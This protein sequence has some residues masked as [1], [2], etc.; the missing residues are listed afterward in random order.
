MEDL[1]A[2]ASS[3]PQLSDPA[4]IRVPGLGSLP[5]LDGA[6]T[7]ELTPEESLLD[8][9]RNFGAEVYYNFY[10]NPRTGA[11][12]QV[13]SMRVPKFQ[14]AKALKEAVR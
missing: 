8:G 4:K 11:A 1:A 10:S 9:M 13:P 2:F 14:A 3:H 6:R 5:V 7:F 12:V